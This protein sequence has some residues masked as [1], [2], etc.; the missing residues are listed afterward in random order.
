MALT[1]AEKVRQYRKRQKDKAEA[2]E[3]AEAPTTYLRPFSEYRREADLPGFG[4]HFLM[5]GKEW[6]DFDTDDGIKPLSLDGVDAADIERAPNSL[7]KAELIIEVLLDVVSQLAS[8]V[9]CYKQ[10]ELDTRIT[11]IMSR[12]LSNPEENKAA[13]AEAKRLGKMRDQLD[14]QVRWTFPQWKATGE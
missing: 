3:R 9:R 7:G 13:F 2:A 5:L 8:D 1:S 12:D 11:E 10:S 6:W 4:S 14:K